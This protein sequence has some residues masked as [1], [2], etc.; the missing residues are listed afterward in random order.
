MFFGYMPDPPVVEDLRVGRLFIFAAA[1]AS[2]AAAALSVF[3]RHPRW[4]IAFVATPAILV[5]VASLL[6]PASLIRH[7]AAMVAFPLAIAGLYQG[8]RRR[9]RSK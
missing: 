5:G 3:L 7:V 1:V 9:S 4:V 6:A 8:L 2:L